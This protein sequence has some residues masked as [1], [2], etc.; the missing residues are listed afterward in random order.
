MRRSDTRMSSRTSG[1][2][3]PRGGLV[4]SGM[5]NS[6]SHNHRWLGVPD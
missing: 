2:K 6:L 1:F 5:G 4:D 3:L